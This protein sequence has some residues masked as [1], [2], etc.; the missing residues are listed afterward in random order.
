[1]FSLFEKEEHHFV[2]I[3]QSIQNDDNDPFFFFLFASFREAFGDLMAS[4][5]MTCQSRLSIS[6]SSQDFSSTIDTICQTY[7]LT[8]EKTLSMIFK[9]NF[10]LFF[11]NLFQILV[12]DRISTAASLYAESIL[13]H[14]VALLLKLT[15]SDETKTL[16]FIRKIT[17]F[18][19]I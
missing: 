4:G 19:I 12:V 8:G 10:R 15:V 14:P 6:S 18:E 16:I 5:T 17:R 9:T 13:G 2:R 11:F 7:R 3:F 1:M